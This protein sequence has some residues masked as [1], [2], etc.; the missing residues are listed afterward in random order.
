MPAPPCL[1]KIEASPRQELAHGGINAFMYSG[2]DTSAAQSYAYARIFDVHIPVDADTELSY[3]VLAQQAN[4]TRVAVDLAFTDGSSL[5]DSGVVD[6]FG[7]RV[8]PQFQGEGG[9]LVIGTW[10]RVRAKLSA[11]AGKVIDE[12]RVGYDQPANTGG[13][14]GY[15]NDITLKSS[16]PGT[17]G[18]CC[19]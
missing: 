1:S 6:Q 3:R 19:S 17:Q 7:V 13:F 12:I 14:R 15:V 11:L 8:H 9:H 10:T 4:R 5:R 18:K 16:L 2:N